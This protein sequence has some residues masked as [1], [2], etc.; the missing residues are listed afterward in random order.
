MV[1]SRLCGDLQFYSELYGN[2]TGVGELYL[3]SKDGN[4]GER[5][6][7]IEI[8]ERKDIVT[9][10]ANNVVID[11]L[12][13]KFTGAHGMGGAGGCKNR[14]VTNCIYSWLGGSILSL[15]FHGGGSPVFYG[16]AVEIYGACDGYYVENN[17]MY[18]IYDTAVTHQRSSSLGDCIQENIH[19]AKNLME[20][21][22]WGI[23]FYNSPPSSAQLNGAEDTYTRITRNVT[24][25][26]NV[27]RL[28]GYGWGSIV[29][30]RGSL[31]YCGSTLSENYDCYT[32]YNIFDRAYGNLLNLPTN[33]NEEID[34]NIYI[35]H[36]GQRL[37]N[38]KTT[39]AIMC[40]YS[41][42]DNISELFGDKNAVVIV[43]DT[44]L[45]P[46]VRNIP[47]GFI[48]PDALY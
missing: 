11:N 35:Q 18:Q 16:N 7:S 33:S 1:P 43:I 13:F 40:D 23:E 15:D 21:V 5:F 29:R 44:A 19:Y 8:G 30:H 17:W 14:I 37:G 41:A 32:R 34:K 38:L 10:S 47:E 24:S 46:I 27:L 9:G 22:F 6:S 39:R 26:Y 20:Y 4:P 45:E 36:V 3:Y 31:L 2:V 12:S 42:K 28:G 48:A 25:E